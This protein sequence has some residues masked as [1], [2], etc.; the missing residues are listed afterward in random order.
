MKL[1]RSTEYAFV[2]LGFIARRR[3]A[4]PVL[5]GA[6][7]KE[8][9]I[10]RDYLLK[11]LNSLVHAGILSSTR[12]PQGGYSLARASKAITMLEIIEAIEG[13]IAQPVSFTCLSAQDSFC[14]RLAE[15]LRETSLATAA[16]FR[17]TTLADLISRNSPQDVSEPSDNVSGQ[18]ADDPMA[19]HPGG[20]QG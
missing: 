13:P 9:H 20:P 18:A 2:A 17:K 16:A 1:S 3:N 4:R 14:T 11:V 19:Q 5:A 10:P 8:Y 15:C 7:A 6:I 12:G